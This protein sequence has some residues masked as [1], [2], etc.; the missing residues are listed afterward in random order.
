MKF[1][2][3][4]SVSLLFSHLRLTLKPKPETTKVFKGRKPQKQILFFSNCKKGPNQN[5]KKNSSRVTSQDY[6][7]NFN[8]TNNIDLLPTS[9]KK[10]KNYCYSTCHQMMQPHTGSEKQKE[11]QTLKEYIISKKEKRT[12]SNTKRSTPA[13]LG[14]KKI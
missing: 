11:Q 7:D 13:H 1:F 3:L 9:C 14:K 5:L 2:S 8:N 10:T 12:L 4:V 6:N